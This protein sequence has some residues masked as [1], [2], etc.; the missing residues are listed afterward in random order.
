MTK[1]RYLIDYENA[2]WCGGQLNVVVWAKSED[3][4]STLAED[5]MEE[6]QRELFSGEYGDSA[7]GGDEEYCDESAVSINSITLLDD[8]HK[9]WSYFT[10]RG[11]ESFYPI[12]GWPY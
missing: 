9:L 8:K 7:D 11:Q 4:A 2:H 5:H 12:V 10:M 6:T 3:E 1:Q